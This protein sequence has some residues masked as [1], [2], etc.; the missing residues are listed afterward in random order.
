MKEDIL[1]LT[2]IKTEKRNLELRNEYL[3]KDSDTDVVLFDDDKKNFTS[4]TKECI[5]NLLRFNVTSS[6]VSSVIE[7]VLNLVG[8][9]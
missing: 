7:C 8:L 1:T 9:N 5:Y 3:E 2:S 4:N 6:N